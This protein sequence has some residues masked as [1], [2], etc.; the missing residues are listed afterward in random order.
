MSPYFYT[1]KYSQ[2]KILTGGFILT[3]T[4]IIIVVF[5]FLNQREKINVIAGRLDYTRTALLMLSDLN[6]KVIDHA[7]S[8]RDYAITGEKRHIASM[9]STAAVLMKELVALKDFFKLSS[10]QNAILDSLSKYVNKRIDFS[11]EIINES[12]RKGYAAASAL[13]QSGLG[14]DYNNQIFSFNS[15][16]QAK[17]MEA[18]Q[19]Y[20][21]NSVTSI[22]GLTYY[23]LGL[24]VIILI[25]ILLI[26]RGI[27]RSLSIREKMELQ[28]K[29]FSKDL[30][31]QVRLKTAT[32]RESEEKYRAVIEQASDAIVISDGN[33]N[34]LEVNNK[35]CKLIGYTKEELTKM[36]VNDL[37]DARELAEKPIRYKELLSGERISAERNMLHKDG[38]LIAVEITAVMISDGRIIAIIR[39]IIDRKKAEARLEA[40]EKN[41]R[42]VLS[43]TAD[44]FY[45]IDRNYQITLLNE[46]AEKNLTKAWGK[47][48]ARGAN[49]LD[50]IPKDS[51][52]PIQDSFE[53]VFQ[54]ER[55]E[56]E[57]YHPEKDLPTWVLVSYAPV[58]DDSGTI[59][60]AY[61]VTKDITERKNSEEELRKSNERYRSLIEQASDYIMITDQKGKFIDVNSSLCKTFGYSRA[62]LLQMNI[63]DLIDKEQL[64]NDPI[65]FALL[66]SGQAILRERRMVSHDGNIIEVE[67]N[68]KMLPDGR[69][70]AIARDIRERKQI[71]K[72]IKE[73]EAKYR[74]LFE[75]TMD[76]I[77]LATGD[78]KVLTANRAACSIFNMTEEEICKAGRDGL[79]DKEDSRLTPFLEKRQLTGKVNGELTLIRKGGIKF[80]AEISTS[81]FKDAN[82]EQRASMIIRDITERKKI[83]QELREA[84]IKFRNLIEKSL[85]GA[86]I[87]Q[88]G[89]FA[90]VNPRFAEIF[91]YTQEE[92]IETFPVEIVVHPDDK[93]KVTENI[94]L[95]MHGE[96]ESLHY[97]ANGLKKNGEVIRTEIFGTMTQ[98]AGKPAIIGTLLDI[99][100]QKKAAE[101]ILRER[102]LS[103]S[104]INSLPGVFYLRNISTG[105]CLRWNKNFETVLNYTH[106]EIAKSKLY[107]FIAAED[108]KSVKEEVEKGM[109]TGS[110][111]TEARI[112]T[113]NGDKIQ[114]FLSGIVIN[115]ENQLCILGTGID[116]SDRK[117]AE[118]E[119]K[120]SYKQIR[121][122]TEHLQNI[123]EEE[124]TGIAREIHDEL[125]QHLTVMKMDASWLNKRLISSE[126]NAIKEKL[127]DLLKLMDNTVKTIRRIS[128]ELRPSILDDMGLAAA[129]EWHLKEFEKRSS[130]KTHSILPKAEMI[131]SDTVKTG[132]FRI[133]QE[134][135]TN[136]LRHAEA[137]NINVSLQQKNGNLVL[138]IEDDGKGFEKGKAEEKKTLGILG[139]KE[140]SFMMGGSYEISSASGKGTLVVVS[141]PC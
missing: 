54:G 84:E 102:D 139:M 44:I 115:Y 19:Q 49:I 99:T 33:G 40:S 72:V 108:R 134:S 90:Y 104:I 88:E 36:N 111:A 77:L 123:R 110:A 64:K 52:E 136:V 12:A 66:L 130:I 50:L 68:V 35:A 16:L 93:L 5:F 62:E 27:R 140:R 128:S 29:K 37:F 124:R 97:E 89:K 120:Q 17:E 8:A 87:I 76:G 103:E 127:R 118:E 13:Y 122:L 59:T 61:I 138:S 92:L 28:L 79:V 100:E 95:R 47:Q 112:V 56:Y 60:G 117:K 82:A 14:R 129:M 65:N 125:G 69:V 1:V 132:L 21:N 85:V 26:V 119:L 20:E 55:V 53:K 46:S 3:I 141:V 24:L 133:F 75:N 45:V 94:R 34:L 18:L 74:A 91:G 30:E 114:Y 11:N 131:L 9:Q 113:K 86:Y 121:Q 43:S 25:L 73:S 107:D 42:Q 48:V 71:E 51:D 31:E 41:L 38:S 67:A 78:G 15:Q 109:K 23:L 22:K 4:A 6:S 96:K 7:G 58:T 101:L 63:N 126:D 116:I 80:P 81:E 57:L 39:D 2:G 10:G 137:E 70:L 32:I 135:L 83:E 105:K 98:S 106:E